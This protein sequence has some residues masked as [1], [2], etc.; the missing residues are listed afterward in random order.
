[1]LNPS[2]FLGQQGG[3]GLKG[4]TGAGQAAA[5]VLQGDQAAEEPTPGRRSS[6]AML[7][8][9]TGR[10][11]AALGRSRRLH[12][13]HLERLPS[14][15]RGAHPEGVAV[16]RYAEWLGAEE[17]TRCSADSAGRDLAEPRHTSGWRL[18][19]RL[20][21]EAYPVRGFSCPGLLGGVAFE[22]FRK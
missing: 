6:F 14:T 9:L 4:V 22:D 16:A 3:A 13:S 11:L 7:R 1:M 12:N 10:E 2:G 15:L 17:P 8:T 20:C 19:W 5:E 18:G 21:P